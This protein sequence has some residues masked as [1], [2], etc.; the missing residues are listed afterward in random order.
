MNNQQEITYENDPFVKGHRVT[1]EGRTK[2]P[3]FFVTLYDR[4][5][6]NQEFRRKNPKKNTFL[7]PLE[8]VLFYRNFGEYRHHVALLKMWQAYSQFALVVIPEDTEIIAKMGLI[9]P[10]TFPYTVK[11]EFWGNGK[12]FDYGNYRI[13]E[14]LNSLF[15]PKNENNSERNESRLYDR[16]GGG[17]TQFLLQAADEYYIH[18]LDVIENRDINYFSL[19]M[20]GNNCYWPGSYDDEGR[21]TPDT[22]VSHLLDKDYDTRPLD[23]PKGLENLGLLQGGEYGMLQKIITETSQQLQ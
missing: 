19:Q 17:A 10:Q 20:S 18:D 14:T 15:G 5:D 8:Q 6:H 12:L 4:D 9:A 7:Q 13:E 23:F 11:R 1:L 21:P 3:K 22:R 16:V 2:F